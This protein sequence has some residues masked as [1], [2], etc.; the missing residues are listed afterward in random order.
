MGFR[1]RVW[2]LGFVGLRGINPITETQKEKN[3][4]ND[5]EAGFV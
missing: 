2:V 4:E 5:I 1:F 3:V